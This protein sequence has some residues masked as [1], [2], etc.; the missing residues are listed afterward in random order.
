M[1]YIRLW[2]AILLT[3]CT[4]KLIQRQL[5]EIIAFTKV[6]QTYLDVDLLTF[7]NWQNWNG[8]LAKAVYTWT[9]I[10]L[11]NVTWIVLAIDNRTQSVDMVIKRYW[12]WFKQVWTHVRYRKWHHKR[13]NIADEYAYLSRVW[14]TA[15]LVLSWWRICSWLFRYWSRIWMK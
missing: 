1:K 5:L 8:Y 4:N 3:F 10:E 11:S 2:F 6:R 15:S 12:K 9:L 13:I 7:F 14:A